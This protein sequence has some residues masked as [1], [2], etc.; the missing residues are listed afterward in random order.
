M[1]TY[2]LIQYLVLQLLKSIFRYSVFTLTIIREY[3][4]LFSIRIIEE[5]I[6]LFSI[7]YYGY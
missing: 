5:Y 7:H 6:P 4:P 1:Y 2:S 3:I